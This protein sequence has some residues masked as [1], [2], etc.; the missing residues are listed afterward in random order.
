MKEL[1]QCK[2][3]DQLSKGYTTIQGIRM[4]G[5]TLVHFPFLQ[6]R[7]GI[8]TKSAAKKRVIREALWIFSETI[9]QLSNY[10]TLRGLGKQ[11]RYYYEKPSIQTTV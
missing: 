5:E 3:P 4:E 1:Q 7:W 10:S 8:K 9:F 11:S 2:E 6:T